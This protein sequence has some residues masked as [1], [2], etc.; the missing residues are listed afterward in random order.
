[1]REHPYSE[2]REE[3]NELLVQYE[4]LKTGRG[5][6]FLEE[7]AFERIIDYFDER[8]DLPGAL[9]AA[10]TG[11][12]Y[13]PYSSQLL[14]KKADILLATRKYHEA[15]EV[16]EHAELFDSQD[17]NLF[18]LKTD[19]Y[20]ALDQQEKAVQLLEDAL[21]LFTGE[22]RI[23]LLF[24]LSDVYDDYEEFDKVFDCLKMILQEEPGNE[25]ALYK[26][27]FWTDFTGR[28]E[29]SIKLHLQ[30]IDEQPFN[31]LAWFN[32]AASYQGIKLYE[33]AI[34]AYQ[35]AIV[36]DEKFDY[37]YRNMG[38]AYIRLRKYK[39]A[40]EALEKVLELTRPEEVI[41]EA[42]GHCYHRLGNF[43]QARIHYRKAS[44]MN[45][46]DSKLY[47]KIAATYIS[48]QQWDNAVKNLDSAMRLQKSVP[49][50]NLAMGQCKMEQEKYKEAIQYFSVVIRSKAKNVAG[51]EALI[52][53][54]FKAGF[55]EEVL[56]QCRAALKATD[57]KPL[58]YF[59]AC[60]GYFSLG[61]PK[62][63]LLYLEH[64]MEKAPKLVKKIL[65]LMPAMLQNNQVVDLIARYKKGHKI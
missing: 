27:C 42:I 30:I 5:H 9:E 17:I 18:I 4:N 19:A 40:I 22:E 14:I 59:Y 31:E 50:Y 48:E 16:L 2:D 52:R 13:F 24:E 12:E 49:E 26:I 62:E 35:Y 37:A 60:A 63:A 28:N 23:D 46:E 47:Y 58:F 56:E 1:M 45:P 54:L 51:W 57:E 65:E 20:L 39:E 21:Q 36:I 38:D 44:H 25:E 15:L 53:C 7:E 34:D 55:Y 32:L 43:A 64:G 41:Y 33:K 8:D 10:E 11:L 6:S 61:M 3:I 29:E